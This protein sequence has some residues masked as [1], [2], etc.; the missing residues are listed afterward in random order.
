MSITRKMNF[1]RNV[2]KNDKKLFSNFGLNYAAMDFCR[3]IILHGTQTKLG[4]KLDNYYYH[5]VEN[6]F[7]DKDYYKKIISTYRDIKVLDKEHIA[8]DA[9]IWIFWWQG[10]DNAPLVVK[11]CIKSIEANAGNHTIHFIDRYN[12]FKFCSIPQYIIDK[13]SKGLITL[14]H[15]S[16]I[17]RLHLLSDNGGIWM[18]ATLF[19]YKLFPEKIYSNSFYTIRH[20][21]YR[22]SICHG[23]WTGF[24]LASTQ[25]NPLICFCKDLIDEYWKYEDALIC[26][27]L[28]DVVISTAYNLFDWA[29][30]LIDTVPDNNQNVFWL[31]EH[32]NDQYKTFDD[33]QCDNCM[34]KM[35]YKIYISSAP[36]TYWNMIS[37]KEL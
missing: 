7:F 19:M 4:T 36:N 8:R 18:D 11:Q 33:K 20:G 14:T 9:P 22:D 26:Y 21:L 32:V 10:I 17:L 34:F 24:F 2:V 12:Y 28:I 31:Q 25:N 1:V 30:E 13:L 5:K 37:G 3:N 35:S 29:K 23:K 16:D 15:F 27:L 6:D